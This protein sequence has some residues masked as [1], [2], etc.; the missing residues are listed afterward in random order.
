MQRV[1]KKA[2]EEAPGLSSYLDVK[3]LGSVDNNKITSMHGDKEAQENLN[4]IC[5]REEQKDKYWDYL[6][7][8][9]QEGKGEDC[10]TTAGVN[11]FQLKSCIDDTNKG[12]KY[13]KAD[14]DLA[15]KFSVGGSPTLLLNDKQTISEF[16]F[17]GRVPNAIKEIVCCANKEKPAFCAKDISKEE[18]AASF[19]KTDAAAAG[20]SNSAAG[21]GN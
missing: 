7:C 16:D 8:Y 13:A 20:S 14:F 5:I 15:S 6:S 4:Q 10:L 19:S 3:Y 21:C 17:G 12:L 18:V 11:S 9:M 1:F 2:I